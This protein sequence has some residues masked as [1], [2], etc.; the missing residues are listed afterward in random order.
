MSIYLKMKIKSL[1]AEARIIRQEEHKE[2]KFGRRCK[3]L[4]LKEPYTTKHYSNYFRLHGHRTEDVRSE[5]RHSLLAYG[6]LRGRDYLQMEQ[7]AHTKP[8]FGR[9]EKIASRFSDMDK[10]E[11]AQ[12]FE[13]WKTTAQSTGSEA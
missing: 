1:S 5:A 4:N 13:E 9:I 8:N 6:F 2:L 10:R 7:S 12:R 3:T 11:F